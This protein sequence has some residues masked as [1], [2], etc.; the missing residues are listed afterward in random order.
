MVK[1]ALSFTVRAALV[2]VC[3]VFLLPGLDIQQVVSIFRSFDLWRVLVSEGVFLLSLL[4]PAVRLV[5]LTDY[6][7]RFFLSM[8]AV[9][10]CLGLNNIFPA[11]LGE[12]AKVSFLRQKANIP[13][14]HGLSIVFWERFFDLNAV[15]LFGVV[16]AYLLGKSLLLVPLTM[17]VGGF[18]VFLILNNYFPAVS[19]LLLHLIPLPR[20]KQFVAAILDQLQDRFGWRFLLV[21]G[22]YTLLAWVSYSIMVFVFLQWVAGLDLTLAQ[23]AAVFVVSSIGVSLPSSPGGLGVYEAAIVLSLGWF[24]V[25]KETALAVGLGLHFIQ[26]FPTIVVSLVILFGTK[27]DRGDLL[28]F[29]PKST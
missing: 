29:K 17:V 23:V 14:S 24:G 25:V 13:M 16:T 2:G 20:L 27:L 28:R 10:L 19:R 8:Q 11:K 18:W 26:I 9:F 4:V 5:F 1:K 7:A 22:L 12:L 3:L 6:R 21:L 15:L